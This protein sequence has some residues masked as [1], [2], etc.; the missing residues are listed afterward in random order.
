M[1]LAGRVVTGDLVVV[2][3]GEGV[4]G[5]DQ[6]PLGTP[7]GAITGGQPEGRHVANTTPTGQFA[8]KSDPQAGRHTEFSLYSVEPLAE[9]SLT[10][11]CAASRARNASNQRRLVGDQRSDSA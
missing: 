6:S 2:A 8:V 7:H 9:S 11:S 3:L 4:G 10:A 5:G 1:G